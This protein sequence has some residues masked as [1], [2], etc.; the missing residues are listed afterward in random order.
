MTTLFTIISVVLALT[1]TV[2]LMIFV[3]PQKKGKDL[4]GFVKLMHDFFNFKFY[5][6]EKLLKVLYIFATSYSIIQGIFDLFKTEELYYGLD[7]EWVGYT[8]VI[9]IFLTPLIIRVVYE[10]ILMAITAMK[11][12]VSMNSKLQSQNGIAPEE[13]FATFNSDKYFSSNK[14]AKFC[15][16]CGNSLD[17]NGKCTNENCK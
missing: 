9:S 3:L 15:S 13:V 14:G 7:S 17:E 6:V 4:G 1:A 10:F 8:A 5:T 12:I 2:L 16:K 11:N